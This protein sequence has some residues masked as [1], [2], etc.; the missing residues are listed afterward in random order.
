M[1]LQWYYINNNKFFLR[2]K[3]LFL[4]IKHLELRVWF[5]LALGVCTI[6]MQ[7]KDTQRE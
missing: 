4:K 1:Y 5:I 7:M 3:K 2:Y 6:F